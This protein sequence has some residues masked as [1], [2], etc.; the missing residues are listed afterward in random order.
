MR[1]ALVF[2]ISTLLLGQ[3]IEASAIP[4]AGIVV[5][6]GENMES[7]AV[8]VEKS[9]WFASIVPAT[10]EIAPGNHSQ[11]IFLQGPQGRIEARILHF[12]TEERLCL[13][14]ATAPL[15][16]FDDMVPLTIAP[17]P[18]AGATV[19]CLSVSNCHCTIVGKDWSYQG[20]HFALPLFRLRMATPSDR[21]RPGT[22]LINREGFLIAILTETEVH[23]EREFYAIPAVRV[24][25][26]V[27]DVKRY[28][29]S[30][31][32]WM[33]FMVHEDSSIPEVLEVRKGSPAEAAGMRPGDIILAINQ[34]DVDS[35]HDL[36]EVIHTL[37]VGEETK[38]RLLRGLDTQSIVVV[39]RFADLVAAK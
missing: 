5:R 27:E 29:R 31:T 15:L 36:I 37:P 4:G 32:A 8:C 10:Y 3:V 11:H 17:C 38:I 16:G 14:E 2:G 39:P 7:P 22:P 30:G 33:G 28:G 6:W 12:D 13:L 21:C 26:I 35:F 20:Q 34:R 24:H 18:K 1:A 25:K 23:P 19:N 9:S